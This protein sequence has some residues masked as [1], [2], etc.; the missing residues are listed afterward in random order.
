MLIFTGHEDG[1]VRCWNGNGGCMEL[2]RVFSTFSLFE[3][4]DADQ[5]FDKDG[6]EEEW[7]PF[8]KVR[9]NSN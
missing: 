5:R 8:R 6:E 1:S 3:A 4:K 7:P 9:I 2:L